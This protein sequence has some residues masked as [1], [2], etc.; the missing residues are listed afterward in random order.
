MFKVKRAIIMAAGIGKRMQPVTLEIPKPLVKVNGVR[1]IDTVIRGLHENGIME[2]YV[3]VGYLK[4]Q[5]RGLEREYDGVQL[6]ENPYYEICNNISSLY[7]ARNYIEDAIILDGDQIIYNTAILEP[8]FERSGYN[9]VW[10]D[11]PTDEWLMTVEDDI[12][13]HCSRTGGNRGWQLFSISRWSVED[14]KRLKKHLE[15]E[16]E[17]KKNWQI[18][19]DDVALFCYPEE[20]QLGIRKMKRGDIIEIDNLYELADLDT[21]YEKFLDGGE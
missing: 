18:Y 10:T 7:V 5:F 20:Y 2:I 12:V 16:F 11:E 14:G 8:S 6:I 19:W 3:V 1:M 17:E 4:E 21:A 9:A 15:I 13:T